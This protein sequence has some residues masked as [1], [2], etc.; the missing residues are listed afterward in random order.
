MRTIE[1]YQTNTVS[2]NSENL[3]Y[4]KQSRV[5][6]EFDHMKKTDLIEKGSQNPFSKSIHHFVNPSSANLDFENSKKGFDT[7][8]ST[9][10]NNIST[11]KI[12]RVRQYFEHQTDQIS[13]QLLKNSKTSNLQS[14]YKTRFKSLSGIETV[15]PNKNLD[16]IYK[17]NYSISN[18]HKNHSSV[19]SIQTPIKRLNTHIE[20]TYSKTNLLTNINK[21]IFLSNKLLETEA[22]IHNIA[23]SNDTDLVLN[24]LKVSAKLNGKFLFINTKIT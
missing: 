23:S 20:K 7:E 9:L 2:T 1:N 16:H 3:V 22:S 11:R 5:Y 15:T 18:T 21:G 4:S 8:F 17:T 19:Y 24:K 14:S 10:D 12:N 6:N 13:P